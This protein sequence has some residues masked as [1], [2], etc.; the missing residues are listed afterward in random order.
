M[1]SYLI[2]HS[3]ITTVGFVGHLIN[4]FSLIYALKVRRRAYN[5]I[6]NDSL[7]ISLHLVQKGSLQDLGIDIVEIAFVLFVQTSPVL[8]VPF[9]L[10]LSIVLTNLSS[11]R[12]LGKIL[13]HEF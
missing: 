13:L 5:A 12:K 3:S 7:V 2:I 4:G 6:H 9:Y 8:L 10:H 11:I 1:A